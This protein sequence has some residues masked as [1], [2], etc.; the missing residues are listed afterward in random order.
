MQPFLF[1]QKNLAEISAKHLTLYSEGGFMRMSFYSDAAC[2]QSGAADT[3]FRK[4]INVIPIFDV[5]GRQIDAV[6]LP[7]K[8]TPLPAK[9]TGI[10]DRGVFYKGAG[11]VY[12]K[13]LANECGKGLSILAPSK[14]LYEKYFVCYPNLRGKFGIFTFSHQPTFSD[15]EGA[16]G[17]KET[18][19]PEMNQR[20]ALSAIEEIVDVIDTG[21]K[22]TNIY[23]YTL[24]NVRSG[25]MD[26][27]NLIEY[28]LAHDY[29]TAWDKN[30]WSDIYCYQY[31]RDLA[32]WFISDRFCHKLGTVYAL[33]N[34]VYVQDVYLYAQLLKQIL[35]ITNGE[36]NKV[37]YYS[38]CIVKKF[39]RTEIPLDFGPFRIELYGALLQQLFQG[40][41]CCHLEADAPWQWVRDYYIN[42][43]DQ[44]VRSAQLKWR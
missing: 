20:F 38:A 24:K 40:K 11:I 21:L 30:L 4:Q 37:L 19:L 10:S 29:N 6:R 33:L 5:G 2:A 16:C 23:A 14:I 18:K 26:T 1:H 41:A 17:Q 43:I 12:Q 8:I 28:V 36:K 13:H 9:R 39:C 25:P 34:S 3:V 7:E 44:Y 22:K 15:Y 32:D 31:V 27:V 42:R 35:G